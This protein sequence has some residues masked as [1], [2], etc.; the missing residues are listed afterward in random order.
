MA[1]YM[2]WDG[3][4]HLT[5]FRKCLNHSQ[6]RIK[7]Y[8]ITIS[9][10]DK[11]QFYLKQMYASN[12]FDKKKM[13]GW[14]NKPKAIKDSFDKVTTY[15]KGL[16]RDYKVYKQNS[17]GTAGKHSYESANQATKA[18]CSDELRQYIA[19]NAKSGFAQEEQAA[20]IHDSAKVMTDTM[21]AQIKAMLDQ[22]P[23]L[24]KAIA[25]KENAPNSGSIGDSGG[26]GGSSG[27]N[28]EQ[29]RHEDVQYDKPRTM[30]S[31]CLSHGFHPAGVNHTCATCS[32]RL[33]NHDAPATWN[34]RKGSSIY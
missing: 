6:V 31:Y 25:N 18:N 8:G 14:E 10:K 19:R 28:K 4:Q 9:D 1:Y 2:D 22:I 29:A 3:E 27:R 17:G 15:F 13:T 16:V 26:G 32:R 20:N 5:A 34:N 23:Q 24:T 21:T 7:R 33:V 11:L 12:H 30:G